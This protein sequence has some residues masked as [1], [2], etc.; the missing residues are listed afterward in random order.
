MGVSK[1]SQKDLLRALAGI[2]HLGRVSFDKTHVAEGGVHED[3]C[4]IAPDSQVKTAEIRICRTTIIALCVA[5][6]CTVNCCM[7]CR[8]A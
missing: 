1:A 4:K 3:S 8:Q 2:L 7:H 6:F 5:Q